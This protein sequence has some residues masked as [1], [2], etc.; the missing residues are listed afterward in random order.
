MVAKEIYFTH[1]M[2]PSVLQESSEKLLLLLL[3]SLL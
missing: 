1:A 3:L 2:A